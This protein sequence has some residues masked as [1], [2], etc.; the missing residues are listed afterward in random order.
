MYG[1]RNR[2][3]V[4]Q[5][6][7][8]QLSRIRR[9]LEARIRSLQ[10]DR[11]VSN[12]EVWKY[13]KFEGRYFECQ[14]LEHITEIGLQMTARSNNWEEQSKASKYIGKYVLVRKIICR[15]SKLNDGNKLNWK[16]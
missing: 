8:W 9:N 3:N 4:V 13:K 14:I 16:T 7:A 11:K 15:K 12:F 5:G 2:Y 10:K 6:R 1:G